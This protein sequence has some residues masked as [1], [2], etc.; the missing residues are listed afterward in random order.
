MNNKKRVLSLFSGCGGMDLGFE[1]NFWVNKECV[2]KSLSKNWI[3]QEKNGRIL[4]QPT[5]FQ[6]VFA[7]DIL[8]A[9][10][11]AWKIRYFMRICGCTRA[12]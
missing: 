9:A 12:A 8:E 4:L 5:I 1:G 6:T 2:N 7:N 3:K 10:E 11:H